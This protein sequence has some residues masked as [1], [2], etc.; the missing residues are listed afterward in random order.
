VRM[1][2]QDSLESAYL[3]AAGFVLDVEL[4]QADATAGGGRDLA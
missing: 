1:G 2:K 3:N 4:E